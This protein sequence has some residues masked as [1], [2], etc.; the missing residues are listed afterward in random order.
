MSKVNIKRAVENIK[1]GTVY[2]PIIEVI[3]NAI[4]AIESKGK[5]N[6]RIDIIIKRS[7]QLELEGPSA[8]ESFEIR[9]NGIGFTDENRD[10]FD[11][12]YSDLKINSGG[13]GF[14]RFICLKY[15]KD[16]TVESIFKNEVF[17]K[18][19]FSMGK[20]NNIIVNEEIEELLEPK[21]TGS[22]VRLL[23]VKDGKF[24]DRKIETIAKNL[25]EKILPYF[26]RGDY[27]CPQIVISEEDDR[28]DPIILNNYINNEL[29]EYINEISIPESE[30]SFSLGT[31][32]MHNFTVRVFKFYSPKNQRSK[33]SLVAHKREVT[34]TPIHN[35]IPEFSEDFY[36]KN[37]DGDNNKERNYIIKAY[38]F[39]DYLD[40]NVSL[41]R[42]GF[43]FKKDNDL[44]YG[45]S[46]KEIEIAASDI[47]QKALGENITVRQEKKGECVKSYVREHAPW[48]QDIIKGIDL[49][50]MPY[51][52]SNE[53]IESRLQKEK[54]KQEVLIKQEVIQLL[55]DN[56]PENLNEKASEIVSRISQNSKNDLIH[57]IALRRKVLDIFKKSLELNP[58]GSYSSEGTV[59]D[60][61]FPRR[62]NSDTTLFKD[63]N[64]WIIDERL[65][66]TEF[67]SSD[68][69]L[70]SADRPDIIVYN[71]RVLFRGDNEPSNPIA[72][73]EFKKPQRDDFTNPSSKEDPVQQIVRYVNS[74]RE[75]DFKTPEG[76][77]I[78]VS[79]NT[80]FYGYIVCD[81]TSKVKK[82][83][84]FEKNFKPMPDHLGWFQWLDNINLYIEVLSWDKILRDATMRN[85]VFFYKLGII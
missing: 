4:E 82:W 58:D 43:N 74:I 34:D 12:L 21:E 9:D 15:F 29:A 52:P 6:G 11:T 1:S 5:E 75:G 59:H 38:V 18:R 78:L 28:A 39:S 73:F 17:K 20:D 77:E 44:I 13:K 80:P 35:Y 55:A 71:K 49:S 8:V 79:K 25:T 32:F 63:H 48:H 42:S 56:N 81:L 22:A 76:R 61:I 19:T 69:P 66:F 36:D 26:I 33:I 70:N 3:V 60:I 40:N 83:L 65:N 27:N 84:E 46:Q 72:I 62:H 64:L 41:E 23:Q 57:Y 50:D 24:T 47:A 7:H 2:T 45:I 68:E 10:S 31:S 51:N 53:E 54:F 85:K 14:G 16:L 67:I 37:S 30:S